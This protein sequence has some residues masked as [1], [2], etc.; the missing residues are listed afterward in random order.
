MTKFICHVFLG[1]SGLKNVYAEPENIK[2]FFGLMAIGKYLSVY[3][4]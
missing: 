4:I 2:A 1:S 3:G